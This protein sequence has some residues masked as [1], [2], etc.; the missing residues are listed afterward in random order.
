MHFKLARK[1]CS[2]RGGCPV[3]MRSAL[4]PGSTVWCYVKYHRNPSSAVSF[5]APTALKPF[6]TGLFD[7]Y[8]GKRDSDVQLTPERNGA[9]LGRIPRTRSPSTPGEQAIR[10]ALAPNVADPVGPSAVSRVLPCRKSMKSVHN[11]LPARK[12]DCRKCFGPN[13]AEAEVLAP[14]RFPGMGDGAT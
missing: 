9:L 7:L 10:A 5:T 2:R 11:E 12:T 3:G 14:Q 13:R 6:V 4:R 8:R 1:D